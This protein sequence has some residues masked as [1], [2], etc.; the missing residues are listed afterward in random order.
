[1]PFNKLNLNLTKLF[2]IVFFVMLLFSCEE[3]KN[4]YFK[5]KIID[6]ETNRGL[7]MVGLI[8][9][10]Q[11][12]YYS[13]SNGL[14]AFN[15]IGLM[16]KNVYFE[17]SS[18]GYEYPLNM[19]GK[20]SVTLF[21]NAGDSI[22]IKLRR[23]NVAERLYRSTGLGIYR[24]SQ[25]L[26]ED[27]PIE[28]PIINAEIIG[29][30]SNLATIYKGKIF[31]V[32]GDTFLPPH[33]NGNFSV[34]AATSLLPEQG[35][36]DP[37]KGVN[38][39]YF[40]D[41]NGKSKPMI[42][43]TKPGYIW[44][45]W[46]TSIKDVEGNEKLVAK[47]ANVN[48][49]FENY[50]RGIAIYNDEKQIF[51]NYKSIPEWISE[52]HTCQHP[53][54][55]VED[56]QRFMYITAEF[57]FLKVKHEIQELASPNNYYAFTCLKEGAKFDLLNPQLDRDKT[58]KLL[59]D[60]KLNTEA[61]G[62]TKQEQL[63]SKGHIKPAEAWIQLTDINTGEKIKWIGRGS[64]YWNA[65]RKKWIL[66][67]GGVDIWFS[68]ADSPIGPWVY[69]KK[70]VEHRSFLYN[71]T[72]H[73]FL[74]Q[75]GGKEIF[76]EGTFTKFLSKEEKVPR[77]DY[78]Q[79]FYKL[80]FED[81]QTFLPSPVYKVD[82]QYLLREHLKSDISKNEIEE[83]G[84]YAM[85]P[86]RK[87]EGL[88]P[89]YQY[90]DRL[91][92]NGENPIF[93][94]VPNTMDNTNKFIGTWETSLNFAHF[95][96]TFNVTVKKKGGQLI[97]TSNKNN[98]KI[99]TVSILNDSI[100]LTINHTEGMYLLKGGVKDGKIYGSWKIGPEKG[101]WEGSI[102]TKKW[103]ALYSDSLIALYEFIN[104]SDI[105]YSTNPKPKPG[106]TRSEKPICKVWKNPTTQILTSF[107]IKQVVK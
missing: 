17:I 55:G 10:S 59:Y 25:L 11:V 80:S 84:F 3:N 69:A 26:N 105:Y 2:S 33:Y 21:C 32:W 52:Q 104:N 106:F 39:E 57:N 103:W 12:K 95:D 99:S 36:L 29:Q 72:Q 60:W 8:P 18:E 101:N 61:I 15:E 31:W 5:I 35:G 96:N 78:N 48:S 7:P 92:L 100:N 88:I 73:P 83:I 47:Y 62:L 54:I 46:I 42:K 9:L 65:F 40:V 28:N 51:E 107:D 44:F 41:K 14:I 50:E 4:N 43:L 27:L 71:P 67:S 34:S 93:Y 85:Q 64:I 79:L 45:D 38:Y 53:F 87:T 30:D 63:I 24:D 16:N 19:E 86:C 68:E 91:S 77:Y 90:N 58:G 70:I 20:R 13:D 81:E 94:A 74:D 49:Y 97:A 98:F 23:K 37:N 1:M 82:N 56:G 75:N 89:I 102:T 66:I 76:F 6:A 22:V